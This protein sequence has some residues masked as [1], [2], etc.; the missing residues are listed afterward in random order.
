[1]YCDYNNKKHNVNFETYPLPDPAGFRNVG[2]KVT[3]SKDAL[4]KGVSIDRLNNNTLKKM[5]D[6]ERLG[7]K[8]ATT[9]Y[10][11]D[12]VKRGIEGLEIFSFKSP[13]KKLN[14]N[15]NINIKKFN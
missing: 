12:R 3:Q 2:S 7:F 4:S 1:M 9:A 15:G 6:V 5:S 11:P 14:F 8:L 10:S 13:K